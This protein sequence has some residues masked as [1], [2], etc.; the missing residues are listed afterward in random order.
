VR[1][2]RW[3]DTVFGRV[4]MEFFSLLKVRRNRVAVGLVIASSPFRPIDR[5]GGGLKPL[6]GVDRSQFDYLTGKTHDLL[7][8]LIPT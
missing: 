3:T 5:I 4:G 7:L 8:G 2:P 1:L 6:R